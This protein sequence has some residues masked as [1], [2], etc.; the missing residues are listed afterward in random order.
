MQKDS[1][2]EG[3][4]D[5]TGSELVSACF[6]TNTCAEFSFQLQMVII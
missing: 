6:I 3:E 4:E 1:Q 5:T 2:K